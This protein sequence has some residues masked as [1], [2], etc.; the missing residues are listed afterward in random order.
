MCRKLKWILLCERSQSEKTANCMIP[1]NDT[2]KRQNYEDSEKIHGCHGLEGGKGWIHGAQMFLGHPKYSGWYYN[3]GYIP[4]Y[5]C[6]NPW[7]FTGKEIP[8]QCRR[9]MFHPWIGKIPRRREW[10][11]TPVFLPGESH[12][13]EEPGGLQSMRSQTP[14]SD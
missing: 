5:I 13:Q 9:Y 14:L 6:L 2:W 8:C 4:L 3:H 10:Q 7:W 12:G 11:P 1:T